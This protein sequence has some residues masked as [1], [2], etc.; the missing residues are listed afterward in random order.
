[1][2]ARQVLITFLVAANL[3]LYFFYLFFPLL[4]AGYIWD[5]LFLLKQLVAEQEIAGQPS[6]FVGT[7]FFRPVGYVSFWVEGMLFG[8]NPTVSHLV[9]IGL[10]S[11]VALQV[12]VFSYALLRE[13][14][15]W[16]RLS[17]ATTLTLFVGSLPYMAEPVAWVSARFEILCAL[18]LMMSIGSY[19][20]LREG[21]VTWLSVGI[22]FVLSLFSK[23][24][25]APFLFVMPV[26]IVMRHFQA[27]SAAPLVFLRSAGFW[28]PVASVAVFFVLYFV[29]RQFWAG[30]SVLETNTM[31]GLSP[32][33]H[34]A[35]VADSLLQYARLLFFPWHD[36]QPFYAFG[37]NERFELKHGF[38]LA[39]YLCVVVAIA[40]AFFRYRKP[41]SLIVL[42]ALFMLLPVVNIVPIFPGLFSVAP[43][44]LYLPVLVVVLM[45]VVYAA[46]KK[47][48]HYAWIACAIM[49][50][51]SV[52]NY[53]AT[54]AFVAKYETNDIF[55]GSIVSASGMYHK[56]VARNL[57]TAKMAIGRYEEAH[58]IINEVREP[59]EFEEKELEDY[60]FPLAYYRGEMS[61]D[62]LRRIDE[63][64][65]ESLSGE[66]LIRGNVE[67]SGA[68]WLLNMKA[69]A[70]HRAC[71]SR[72]EIDRLAMAAERLSNNSLSP[73]LLLSARVPESISYSGT[74][75]PE[76]D[77]FAV[78]YQ[79][80]IMKFLQRDIDQCGLKA[81][82]N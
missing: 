82:L 65:Q 38:V 25:A 9:N 72:H 59:L 15:F 53:N 78:E 17:I 12:F 22:W 46:R 8:V 29:I 58:K 34:S 35:L 52:G 20:F 66:Q 80:T 50:L 62:I 2:A 3:L 36:L 71:S 21:L 60:E 55:W 70:L 11:I 42:S 1:M 23:E 64:L 31:K 27:F 45:S 26:M 74:H 47:S 75:I 39:S 30:Q 69:L 43:R 16:T 61:G 40:I 13:L 51:L 67:K 14:S 79:K 48:V 76:Q 68:A 77:L 57:V 56:L 81:Y 19:L 18:F 6:M 73:L 24:A 44:Y 4:S 41:A 54:R 28:G 32:E 33:F 37:E 7:N 5:D 10:H 49:L 63:G